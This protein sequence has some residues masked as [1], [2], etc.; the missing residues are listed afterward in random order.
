MITCIFDLRKRC[1][2]NLKIFLV[3]VALFSGCK[4]DHGFKFSTSHI[5]DLSK[6]DFFEDGYLSEIVDTSSIKKVELEFSENAAIGDINKI[7][8][9]DDKIFVFDRFYSKKVIAFDLDG[10]FL[11]QVGRQGDGLGEYS[12]IAD[13]SINEYDKQIILLDGGQILAYEMGKGTYVN[14]KKLNFQANRLQWMEDFYAFY[15]TDG[16]YQ[17]ILTDSKFQNTMRYFKNIRHLFQPYQSFVLSPDHSLYFHLDL[18][19]T[20][21]K[22]RPELLP[23]PGYIID[24]GTYNVTQEDWKN[25]KLTDFDK[26]PSRFAAKRIT[27]RFFLRSDSHIYFTFMENEQLFCVIYSESSKNHLVFRND[28][29]SNDITFSSNTDFPAVVACNKAGDFIAFSQPENPQKNFVITK[30]RWKDF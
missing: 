30:F 16:D 26:I 1:F 8:E 7:I 6:P 29:I 4:S 3:F 9:F 18:H 14:S 23:E 12:G 24:Y 22:L 27:T 28:K 15:S 10:N 13:F 11:Y 20:I 2:L 5:L 17:L 25:I 19:D 21:Y